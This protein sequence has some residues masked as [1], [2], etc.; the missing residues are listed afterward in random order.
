MRS[1]KSQ[2]QH[3]W[4]FS[5]RTMFMVPSAGDDT[6][7]HYQNIAVISPDKNVTANLIAEAQQNIQSQLFGI[8]GDPSIRM[9][10]THIASINYLGYMTKEE[11]YTPPPVE[12]DQAQAA[13]DTQPVV[14]VVDKSDPFLTKS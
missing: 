14:A 13:N 1:K 8:I 9:I 7:I 10:D 6:K 12:A 2:R 5:T 3:H 11:F 4:L